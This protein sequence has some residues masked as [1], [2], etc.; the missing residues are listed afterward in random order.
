MTRATRRRPLLRGALVAILAA[1]ATCGPA[2]GA[3]P[4]AVPDFSH[5]MVVVMENKEYSQVIGQADAPTFARLAARYASLT[6]YYGVSHPSLPNYL[7]LVSGST[8]G[9]TSD[10]TDCLIGGPSLADTLEASGRTWKTYAE[11]LPRAG[12]LVPYAGRYAMKHDPFAYFTSV[13]NDPARLRRIVPLT[14]L[15]P[16]LAAGRLPSFSLVVP[17][18]CHDMH[19]CPVSTGDAWLRT[20][21]PP[22]L[23]S[24]QMRGGVVFVVFDEG[25]T[26]LRGGGHIPSL[27]LGA[28]VRT[29][30]RSAAT[31]DHYGLLRT[32]EDAWG[33]PRLGASA[34]ARP[35]TGIWRPDA[36][37]VTGR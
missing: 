37:G 14:Q 7:A 12:S 19:D 22:V 20:F 15:A 27:V 18:L 25:T 2:A 28:T 8:H 32:I 24:P 6:G 26:G 10:C 36:L 5:V 17:D 1:C 11:G 33:L 34:Q 3:A 30:S 16:D 4:R 29:G 21:L 35:I 13:R 31:T 9:I 23:A